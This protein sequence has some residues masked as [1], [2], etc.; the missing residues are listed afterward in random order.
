MHHKCDVFLQ[1]PPT[2]P[3]RTHI[4]KS[5]ILLPSSC[6][7]PADYPFGRNYAPWA[8]I[9][10]T[11]LILLGTDGHYTRP[12]LDATEAF[13]LAIAVVKVRVWVCVRVGACVWVCGCVCVGACV[14]VRVCGCVCAVE[15]LILC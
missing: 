7:P 2:S 15:R 4:I 14:W 13:N 6:H 5:A 11:S 10:S 3:T 9:A 12:H 1:Q 8:H